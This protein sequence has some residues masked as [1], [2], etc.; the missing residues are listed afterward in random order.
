MMISK[1]VLTGGP[2]AGKTKVLSKIKRFLM[3]KGY[4]VFV[5]PESATE[6]MAGGITPHK[7]NVGLYEFQKLILFYQYQKELIYDS[8][9]EQFNH[10]E[11]VIIYDRGIMDNKAYIGN[12]AYDNL[13]CDLSTKVGFELSEQ[14]LCDRYDMV[15]HLVTSAGTKYFGY[16]TN[17]FRYEKEDE[18]LLLDQKTREAWGGHSNLVII[19][20]TDNFDDKVDNVFNVVLNYLENRKGKKRVRKK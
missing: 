10:S 8:A 20:S 12:D 14:E 3:E 13:V 11:V 16:D 15:L 18:A 5:V 9:A 2:C 17:T 19:D 6:L 7:D 1:I 4:V